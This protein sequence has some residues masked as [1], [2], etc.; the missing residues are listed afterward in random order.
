MQVAPAQGYE[1]L[2]WTKKFMEEGFTL[3]LD[4]YGIA[5]NQDSSYM[6]E[7]PMYLGSC[8]WEPSL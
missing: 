4:W 7:T 6:G 8:D 3:E 2:E 5:V 1:L